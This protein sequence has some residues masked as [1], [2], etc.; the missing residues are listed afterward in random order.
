[1]VEE[2]KKTEL[3]R[4]FELV[5]V[6]TQTGIFIKNNKTGETLDD[7]MVLVDILNS[8]QQLKDTLL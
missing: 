1:M 8:I 4:T 5:E 7:K 2:K 6:P 3:S